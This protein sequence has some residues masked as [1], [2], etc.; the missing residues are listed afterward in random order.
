MH[1]LLL[2][3]PSLMSRVTRGF[4][5]EAGF[6]EAAGFCDAAGFCE[7]ADF[8]EEEGLF[9]PLATSE[10]SCDLKPAGKGVIGS[11]DGPVSWM[12]WQASQLSA[13]QTSVVSSLV[14]VSVFSVA[15]GNA[16]TKL[17]DM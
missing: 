8:C 5:E 17:A 16:A 14:V 10:G 13:V 9:A 15:P 6:C 4:F 7:E 12:G 2:N 1:S 3:H 11:F